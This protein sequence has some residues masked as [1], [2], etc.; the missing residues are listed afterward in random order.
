MG[1]WGVGKAGEIEGKKINWAILGGGLTTSPLEKLRLKDE[2]LVHPP[3]PSPS[4]PWMAPVS[5]TAETMGRG[6]TR[7]VRD[8]FE[9][10]KY[11]RR[12]RTESTTA[13]VAYSH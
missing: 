8:K 3:A 12:E 2:K 5:P 9:K 7:N 6:T 4:T 11:P 10:F 13:H 1:L